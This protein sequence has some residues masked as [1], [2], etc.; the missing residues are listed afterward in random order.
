MKQFAENGGPRLRSLDEAPLKPIHIIAVAASLGGAALDGYVLGIVGPS[1]TLAKQELALSALSQGLIAASA[2]IGVFVGGMF[3]GNLADKYGRRPVFAY[4][5]LAFVVLSLLQLMVVEV[6]QLV[7]LRLAL[8]LAIGVEYAVGTSVLAEFSRRKGR[9]VLLGCFSVGWQVGFTAAF[10]IGNLYKGDDWRF[11]LATSAVPALITFL[12]RLRLPET[13]MWLKARGRDTEARAVVTKHF[14]A[15]YDIPDVVLEKSHAS[16][17]ELLTSP[18][19]RQHIY[20][21]LFWF[22]Q[23]GPFFAIFTFVGPVFEMLQIHD[24]TVVDV[25]LNTVQI[26]GAIFGLFLLHWLTR[27]HFVISTFA[28]MFAVLLAIGLFPQAPV[29]VV[30]ALFA[31]YMFVAPA[32][33]NIEYVYPAEIFETRL[34]STGVGFSAAFSRIS[35][36]TAVYLLPTSLEVLGASK[37]MIIMAMF[38]LIGLIFS[39]MWAPE[40]KRKQL[41]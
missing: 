24:A 3:F 1:L 22:C 26:L 15:E 13:P 11:L 21:G 29:W 28:V 30:V 8:G 35:A 17:V 20:S 34:R 32:A 7:A 18:H 36:A 16:P 9:G 39:I 6:W 2:L 5:L 10:I 12:L 41:R 19:W 14:G 27:R 38:P 23:V 40:T 4:N 33:N 31:I 25:W 37:T